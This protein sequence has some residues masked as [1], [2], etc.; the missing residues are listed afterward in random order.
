MIREK[1]KDLLTRLKQG[2]GSAT[3]FGSSYYDEETLKIISIITNE[4]KAKLMKE[5]GTIKKYESNIFIQN[6]EDIVM[7]LLSDKNSVKNSLV[8]TLT[9]VEE[10]N[11]PGIMQEAKV[12]KKVNEKGIPYIDIDKP[13]PDNFNEII[14]GQINREE[15]EKEVIKPYIARICKN[16]KQ[17]SKRHFISRIFSPL[18]RREVTNSELI[19]R[20]EDYLRRNT[21]VQEEKIQNMSRYFVF[22][23]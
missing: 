2:S 15:L 16:E 23:I 21:D 18:N 19:N 10:R 20:F 12:E 6:V 8:S 4:N 13:L 1:A 22:N 14:S 7:Q 5:D 17:L 11:I 3:L 9:R